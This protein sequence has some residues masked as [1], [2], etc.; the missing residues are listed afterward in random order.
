MFK[1]P[2]EPGNLNQ[3]VKRTFESPEALNLLVAAGVLP[4]KL[5]CSVSLQPRCAKSPRAF[6]GLL[7]V[8]SGWSKSRDF[9]HGR[10]K[11]PWPARNRAFGQWLGIWILRLYMFVLNL[12]F[13]NQVLSGFQALSCTS[14]E[15]VRLWMADLGSRSFSRIGSLHCQ[16]GFSLNM[17][18]LPCV[19]LY[20]GCYF[21]GA[22]WIL[23]IDCG[24]SISLVSWPFCQ[25]IQGVFHDHPHKVS[26]Y[27]IELELTPSF[28]SIVG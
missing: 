28:Y 13:I 21:L 10:R 2:T 26:I 17:S 23:T 1:R 25:P 27:I 3:A 19:R 22:P 24:S 15:E 12:P 9:D 18:P 5:A 16:T 20:L 7:Q 6:G 14:F 4:D 11:R 8:G